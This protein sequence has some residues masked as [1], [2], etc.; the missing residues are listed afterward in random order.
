ME[1]QHSPP[2]PVAIKFEWV[3]TF[4]SHQ[5]VDEVAEAADVLALLKSDELKVCPWHLPRGY[6]KNHPR[7]VFSDTT[8]KHTEDIVYQHPHSHICNNNVIKV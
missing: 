5:R 3:N 1:T 4:K 7:K 2:P 8:H 6:K